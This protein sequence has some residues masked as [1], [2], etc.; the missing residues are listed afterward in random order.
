MTTYLQVNTGDGQGWLVLN[1]RF[2][3]SDT[4]KEELRRMA[5]RWQQNYPPF[6]NARFRLA[7]EIPR[8]R[9]QT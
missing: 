3:T 9:A 6:A 7:N 4:T 5:A 1:T 8:R 2:G